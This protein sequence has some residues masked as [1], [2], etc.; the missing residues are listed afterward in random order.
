[1]RVQRTVEVLAPP[2]KVFEILADLRARAKFMADLETWEH[3]AGPIEGEGGQYRLRQRIGPVAMISYVQV[4]DWKPPE[5]F[6]WTSL[7]GLRTWGRFTVKPIENGS[8]VTLRLGYASGENLLS[9]VVDRVAS[10]LVRRQVDTTLRILADRV[11]EHLSRKVK[12]V[13]IQAADEE[14]D[15]PPVARLTSRPAPTKRAP[16]RPKGL[17]RQNRKPV[18]R[19]ASP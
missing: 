19:P 7:K 6:A 9:F 13:A 14:A 1:M 8:R 2:E 12:R 10:P 5:R 15:I 4:V 16:R 3:I 11:V 17:D 18:K